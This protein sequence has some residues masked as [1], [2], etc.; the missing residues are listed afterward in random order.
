MIIVIA[1]IVIGHTTVQDKHNFLILDC[2]NDPAYYGP[3]GFGTYWSIVSPA[4]VFQ[5]EDNQKLGF[6]TMFAKSGV[7]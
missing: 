4:G 6:H 5:I 7:R 1:L 2:S 3:G